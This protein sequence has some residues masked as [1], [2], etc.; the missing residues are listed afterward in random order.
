MFCK[1][2]GVRV[3]HL[4]SRNVEVANVKPGT[5]DDRRWLYPVGHLWTR[6]A[7]PWVVIPKGG[8]VYEGQPADFS[9]LY[10]AWRIRREQEAP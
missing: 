5:L 1:D 4:P 9:P 2:C 3:F 10:E 7:Q 6:S 8:L